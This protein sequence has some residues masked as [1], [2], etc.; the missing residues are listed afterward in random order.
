MSAMG[1]L[2]KVRES[3]P[4]ARRGGSREAI[5]EAA[6]RLFLERGFGSVSMAELAEAAG[7]ARR[8]PLQPVREQ[9]RDLP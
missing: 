5:V 2:M 7:M 4:K 9:G 1:F 8:D 3:S 6:E